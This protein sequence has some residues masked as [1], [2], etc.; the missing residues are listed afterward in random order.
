MQVGYA[1]GYTSAFMGSPILFRETECRSMGHEACRVVGRPARDWNEA[2]EDLRFFNAQPFANR[3]IVSIPGGERTTSSPLSNA[4]RVPE[5]RY[6]QRRLMG[7]S[8]AFN[9]TCHM[10]NRVAKTTTPVLLLGESGVGKEMFAKILHE[11]SDRSSGPFVGVNCAAIPDQLIEADLF[12]VEK[13]AFTGASASKPG[14]FER[15]NGGTLLL[16]EVSCL[17]LAAQA[18]LL[19]VLQEG[20]FERVGDSQTRTVDVRIVAASNEDL[21]QSVK[22]G[23]FRQDLFYRLDVFPILVPPLRERKDDIPILAD[24]FLRRFSDLHRRAVTGF[25]ED[26]LDALLSYHWPGNVR[27]L[28]NVIERATLL[29][30]VGG[31]IELASLPRRLPQPGS[32]LALSPRRRVMK[33]NSHQVHILATQM[34][35]QQQFPSAAARTR[36]AS[37]MSR[38]IGSS[39]RLSK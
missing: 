10:I 12:G 16:D 8:A 31:A 4:G 11:T 20:T 21:S 17:S 37:S 25:S 32:L 9:A 33:V 23:K 13:G 27:Q 38:N 35:Y 15:A 6:D 22:D 2:Q 14:R 18:K 29:T 3:K 39:R 19:R 7:V 36:A 24:Y 34:S 26:G 1:C 28:E 30:S 5:S